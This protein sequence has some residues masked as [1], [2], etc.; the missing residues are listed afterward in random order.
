MIKNYPL[1]LIAFL[2][3]SLSGYGQ[4][5]GTGTFTKITSDSELTDGYYVI[6]NQNDEY[7]MNNTNGGS[8]FEHSSIS[9]V[10]NVITNP[11]AS[12]VWE[13]ETNGAGKTIYNEN[14]SRYVSYTGSSNRAYAAAAVSDD[15]QRWTFSYA[16][17]KFTVLNVD[18]SSRQLSYN[19]EAP[20]F[21]AYDN[22]GQQELQ[23]Y[24][25]DA[26]TGPTLTASPTTITNL[27]YVSGNGPSTPQSF[28]VTGNLLTNDITL[29][30]P[31]NQGFEI[32]TSVAGTYSESITIDQADANDTNIIYVRLKSGLLGSSNTT[33]SI[34][35]GLITTGVDVSGEVIIATPNITVTPNTITG[36]DYF[37]ND[38]PSYEETFTVEGEDLTNNIVIT[39]PTDFEI[40]LTAGTGFTNSITLNES[41]GTVASTTIYARLISGKAIGTYTGNVNITSTGAT[42]K[43][44]SVSGDVVDIYCTP[45]PWSSTDSEIE[46]VSLTGENDIIAFSSTND[47]T[48]TV[49]DNTDMSADLYDGDSYTLTVEFGDCNDGTYYD[50]AGA[51]WIDWNQD[52]DFEDTDEQIGT[53][54]ID[55]GSANISHDFT[56]NV[57]FGQAIGNYRM[58]IVQ[59]EGE[60]EAEIDP[61]TSPGWGTIADYTIEVIASCTPTHSFSSMLPTSG[62]EDTEITVTGTGF[63]ASTTASFGGVSATVDFIDATTLIVHVP[64]GAETDMITL[65]EASCRLQTGTFT[66]IIEESGMCTSGSGSFTDLIISEVFDAD[67]GSYH[68][69][70]LFNPTNSIIDLSNYEVEITSGGVSQNPHLFPT[71]NLVAGGT[72]IIALGSNSSFPCSVVADLENTLNTNLGFDESGSAITLIKNSVDIDYLDIET[73]ISTNSSGFSIF[74]DSNASGPTTSFNSADWTNVLIEDCSN[75][76][77]GLEII[78][79]LP[80][81]SAITDASDCAVLDYSIT[82]TEGD[83]DTFGDLTYQWY[84]NNGVND[85][86][87]AVTSTFP[88]GYTILGE[89]GD[90]LLM[91]GDANILSDLANYQFYC[92]VTEAGSCTNVSNAVKPN[93]NV[94]TWDGS[95]S[96]TPDIY[97]TLILDAD[98]NTSVGGVQSSFSACSLI[99]N[100]EAELTIANNT[101]VKVENDLTVNG[102]IIVNTKGS[103]VQVNDDGDV[104]GAVLTTRNK[105]TVE[106]QTAHLASAQ[107]Y[108]YWSAPVE[109]EKISDGLAEA[110]PNR[111]YWYKAQNYLDA[112]AETNNNGDT[113]AGQDDIDDNG[114]DWQYALGSTV[115]APGV[116]YGSTHS[117]AT[118]VHPAPY[119]YY[120]EGPFNNGIY[121]VPIYRN[122]SELDDNNWNLIGNPYPSAIDADLFLNANASIGE[123]VGPMTG[124]I[125]FWSHASAASANANGN[126]NLNYAQSD[127][128]IINGSGQTEGG[129]QEEP[130]RFIP[131]GQAFFISMD[132]DA[133]S[134]SVS[135]DI[136]ETVVLFNNSMRVTGNNDQFFRSS[137]TNESN[138]LWLNLT[139]DNGAFNQILVAYVNGA[140]DADDGMY[141]DAQRNLSTDVNAVIYSLLEDSN[142]KQFAIQGKEPNNLT[143]EEVIPLGFITSIN[144]PTI[145]TISIDQFEGAFMTDNPIYIKDNLLNTTHN[146]KNSDYTFTSETGEFDE[147]FE[148][149]FVESALST[150]ENLLNA[151]DLTITELQNGHVEFKVGSAYTIKH[152]AIIDVTGRLIYSLQGNN[153][154]EIY[155]LSRLSQAAYVA[156]ITL[157]NGQV[158]SKKAIKK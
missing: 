22:A 13:I 30:V 151:N 70:E 153:T 60:N 39:A 35:D 77:T 92:E 115:M 104:N 98:Y 41:S 75:L 109:G 94:V 154:T 12:I 43:T 118:F 102:D 14:S 19:S 108:T 68:Y 114:D 99:I 10:S 52:G 34:T 5:S 86:W 158:M 47:C 27:D 18:N 11:N 120:F 90:N 51:V 66:I 141:Y 81:M 32:S 49:Q 134:T 83:T 148:I 106:K 128:A 157:S 93:Y 78:V 59:D 113:D 140:T 37:Y 7:A 129:D 103:F 127:Y 139:T 76:G 105:I 72:Y 145:Y 31:T 40:S 142:S 2:C 117:S 116:G 137:T 38:S 97:S 15:K 25:L 107:E 62:P 152:V 9:P 48:N 65:T 57:P 53:F 24:K 45:S 89:D 84:F 56:I 73:E 8:Y 100:N 1:I 96:S 136:E 150:D 50:G 20:R 71:G 80:T 23:L 147:R 82:A 110:N 132:N 88:A 146:L 74:R 58:R 155:D 143:P 138:R 55:F 95:W 135:D 87:T 122:D 64:A 91:E 85:V 79:S 63:T 36:L 28:E 46:G 133:S 131:S 111:I 6:T 61:C 101:F 16:S 119:K 17:S 21:A 130:N 67:T 156:K 121:N 124:A 125:F 144:E 33:I 26:P 4:Y 29:T 54:D 149:V 126:E 123:A 42:T 44:V 69:I 3:F 112:T